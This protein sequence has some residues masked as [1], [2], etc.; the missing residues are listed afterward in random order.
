MKGPFRAGDVPLDR[1]GK[2]TKVL[3]VDDGE[4]PNADAV[5]AAIGAQ[6]LEWSIGH[7]PMSSEAFAAETYTTVTNVPV[8][9][10][11]LEGYRYYLEATTDKPPPEQGFMTK[12]W[13]MFGGST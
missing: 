5:L 7:A 11:E 10:D 2:V 1:E 6:K 13:K 12:F 8:T 9:D 4:F 3:V